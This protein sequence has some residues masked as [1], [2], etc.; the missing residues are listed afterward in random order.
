MGNL[1]GFDCSTC[2][3]DKTWHMNN[4]FSINTKTLRSLSI[5][6]SLRREFLAHFTP[7]P[8]TFISPS[9]MKSHYA[10]ERFNC[11]HFSLELMN[12]LRRHQEE[13]SKDSTE[14]IEILGRKWKVSHKKLFARLNCNLRTLR[15]IIRLSIASQQTKRLEC[16][17]LRY[18]SI[19]SRETRSC[20]AQMW[21]GNEV[22]TFSVLVQVVKWDFVFLFALRFVLSRMIVCNCS[23]AP[24]SPRETLLTCLLHF[25]LQPSVQPTKYHYYPHNQQPYFLPECAIQQ[26]RIE[27]SSFE[28][29]PTLHFSFFHLF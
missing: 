29:R 10:F 3:P 17:R 11:F 8:D 2:V 1:M 21:S 19:K 16:D 7:L 25:S 13:T 22:I 27:N 24:P 12:K 18:K 15:F 26:V 20:W 28:L 9:S 23:L 4:N 14:F 6:I 5:S